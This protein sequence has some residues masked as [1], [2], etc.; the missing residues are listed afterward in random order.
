MSVVD[1]HTQLIVYLWEQLLEVSYHT[2]GL[3]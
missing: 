3:N 2:A 1:I